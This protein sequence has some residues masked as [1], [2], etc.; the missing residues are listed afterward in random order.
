MGL[1]H[2]KGEIKLTENVVKSLELLLSNNVVF[3][4]NG[5]YCTDKTITKQLFLFIRKAL[6]DREI[7]F[8]K[9]VGIKFNATANSGYATGEYITRNPNIGESYIELINTFDDKIFID[10]TRRELA[11]KLN[12]G[13][14]T[15]SNCHIG[16]LRGEKDSN[17]L[18][19]NPYICNC[20]KPNT[21]AYIRVL[22]SSG[23]HDMSMNA[24]VLNGDY[25]PFITDFSLQNYIRVLPIFDNENRVVLRYYNGM[26][27]E[28]FKN[29]LNNWLVYKKGGI[30]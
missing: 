26:T 30:A 14:N 2:F 11:V 10:E 23:Y 21:L 18:Y 12:V 4:T 8:V 16:D 29:I 1:I 13:A 17:I 24:N 3:D 25:F 6:L 28:L 22:Y 19:T 5:F 20:L 7:P 27:P 9:A 15:C